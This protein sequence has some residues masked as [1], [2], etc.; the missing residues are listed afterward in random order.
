M[1]KSGGQLLMACE[2]GTEKSGR[3]RKYYLINPKRKDQ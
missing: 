1:S 2:S 3:V